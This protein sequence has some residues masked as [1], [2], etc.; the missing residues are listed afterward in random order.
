MRTVPIA[1]AV[2]LD[3]VVR[4]VEVTHVLIRRDGTALRRARVGRLGGRVG[5]RT[6]DRVDV[7][8]VALLIA[9]GDQHAV[10]TRTEQH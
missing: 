6:G 5:A 2:R 7:P 9:A 8:W 3:L 10:D 4:D 1:T